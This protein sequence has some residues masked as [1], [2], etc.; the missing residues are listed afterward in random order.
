MSSFEADFQK[1][2][3]AS[4]STGATLSDV[5]K[6]RRLR[7]II[8]EGM[9]T[10]GEGG[11]RTTPE[12]K[13]LVWGRR[14]GRGNDLVDLDDLTDAELR[15]GALSVAHLPRGATPYVVHPKLGVDYKREKATLYRHA[16]MGFGY[17][18]IEVSAFFHQVRPYAQY[19]HAHQLIYLPK[20]AR[21]ARQTFDTRDP[22]TIV[23][24]G[25][26]HPDPAGIMSG[27]KGGVGRMSFD[28]EWTR[29][30]DDMIDAY[31]AGHK[32][33]V[34]LDLRSK[35]LSAIERP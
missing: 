9:R 29:E 13:R 4:G 27:A 19:D 16:E 32:V 12:G 33:K 25:W 11:R 30:F 22:S 2:L 1:A 18:K 15:E 35:H 20:G 24:R 3:I 21:I 10:Y 31:V 8:W 26:G 23:L 6:R 7:E 28:P 14:V 34:L 17:R 5:E